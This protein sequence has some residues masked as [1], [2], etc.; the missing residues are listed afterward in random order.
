MPSTSHLLLVPS[1]HPTE[2]TSV[3]L[4]SI[5]PSTVISG[6]QHSSLSALSSMPTLVTMVITEKS[7]NTTSLPS[8]AP[9]HTKNS[10]LVIITVSVV[11][12]LAAL[13]VAAS[14]C[15][16]RKQ[17][18]RS[19][20]YRSQRESAVELQERGNYRLLSDPVW[21]EFEDDA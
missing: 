18:R 15:L 19:T 5:A 16:Y 20:R 13:V 1:P 21:D 6:S 8:H 17:R 4:S 7:L 10:H 2:E 3:G 11:V 12:P 9:T 14:I